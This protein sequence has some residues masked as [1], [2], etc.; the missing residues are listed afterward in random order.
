MEQKPESTVLVFIVKSQDINTRTSSKWAKFIK[1]VEA[2]GIVVECAEKSQSDVISMITNTAKKQGCTISPE[3]AANFAERCL[4]DMLLI[5]NDL[6]KLCAFAR[7]K[8]DG[9]ITIDAIENLTARQLDYKAF[10]IVRHII[11]KKSETALYV[12]DSLF[13]QQ[14]D[15]IAIN[16]ALASSFLDIYRVKT[17]QTYNHPVSELSSAYDYKGK[18]YKLRGA[19][20]DAQKCSLS[21]LK[22]AVKVLSSAD[23]ILKSAKDDKKTVMEKAL[24]SIILEKDISTRK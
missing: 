20:Y 3:L 4:N 9:A 18:E 23:I 11:N 21:F 12:L 10:E 16:S 13:L 19:G 22:N 15:A 24:L 17:M 1:T 7:E 2:S 14:V 6:V 5:E 8:T